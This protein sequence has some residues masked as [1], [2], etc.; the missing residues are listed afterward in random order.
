MS[1]IKCEFCNNLFINTNS[2]KNH[3]RVTK[4]CLRKQDK[5]LIC[6]C[7]ITF[8]SKNQFQ[9]HLIYPLKLNHCEAESST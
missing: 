5:E 1:K 8:I 7:K 9:N 6:E 2:L 3:Q 4:Y